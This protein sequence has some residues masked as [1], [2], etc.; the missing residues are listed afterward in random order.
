MGDN[1]DFLHEYNLSK[2]PE[3]A[4]YAA[5]GV[6][7]QSPECIYLHVDPKSKIP[8]CWNYTNMGFCPD[9]PKCS[10]RHI[11][12]NICENYLTGFCPKGKDCN[13]SH[14][15]FKL[16]LLNGRFKIISD[17]EI[18]KK[19]LKDKEDYDAKMRLEKDLRE[20]QRQDNNDT[21]NIPQQLIETPSVDIE[22]KTETE[23]DDE[24]Q[25]DPAM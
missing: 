5:N 6:C 16:T 7:S 2:M 10:K 3:C 8:G 24:D 18:L 23:V 21:K 13:D 19:R 9:G 20:R 4:Y 14:P 11:R 17:E 12:R 22:M 15:K 25:Y 1:C